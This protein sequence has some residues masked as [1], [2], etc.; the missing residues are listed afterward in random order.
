MDN[1]KDVA[2][3]NNER[4]PIEELSD[5]VLRYIFDDDPQWVLEHRLDWIKKYH[6]NLIN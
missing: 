1:D 6:P 3:I 4:I 2:I 5:I